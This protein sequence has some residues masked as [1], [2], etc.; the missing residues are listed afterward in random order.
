[1]NN[2]EWKKALDKLNFI[3]G[4]HSKLDGYVVFNVVAPL[5]RRL[6]SGEHSLNLYREIMRLDFNFY[7]K[8]NDKTENKSKSDR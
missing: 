6:L 5:R 3:M 4:N 8:S 2:N 7:I 1:M